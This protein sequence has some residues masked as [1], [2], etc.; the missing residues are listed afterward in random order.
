ML[1]A[2]KLSYLRPVEEMNA[3]LEAH[4]AWL[5]KYV[6]AGNVLFAGPLTQEKGGLIVAYAE[7]ESD[8]QHIIAED[9][10]SIHRLA[11]YDILGCDPAIRTAD[12][13]ERWASGAKSG[14][15]T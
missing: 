9:P 8:I 15:Q 5:F 4:K 6:Q 13:A 10:F 12:F 1:F 11:T 3:H 2:I 14:H 7:H